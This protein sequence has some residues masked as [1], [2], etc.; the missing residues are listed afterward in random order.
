MTLGG[1]RQRWQQREVA[2]GCWLFAPTLSS[3]EHLRD[4][5]CDF[6]AFDMQH[7][8]VDWRDVHLTLSALRDSDVTPIVRIPWL[9]P[10]AA[11]RVLDAGVEGVVCPTIDTPQQCAQFVRAC[12]YPP[13]GFRSWGPLRR[14]SVGEALESPG[15][16]NARVITIPQIES[17]T[18]LENV[19]AIVSTPG[20]DA[21]YVGP[22][23]LSL[24]EGGPPVIDYRD[25]VA[26]TKFRHIVAECHAAGVKA[27]FVSMSPADVPILLEWGA[28]LIT[29]ASDLRLLTAGASEALQAARVAAGQ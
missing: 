13:D 1:V 8:A 4:V 3:V 27:G 15:E 17:A 6:I 10:S 16:T 2:F 5:G 19:R 14:R 7:G 9:D 11:M 24:S 22:A 25:E 26:A 18:A 12:R 20:V 29:V 21:V 23:D 28:D